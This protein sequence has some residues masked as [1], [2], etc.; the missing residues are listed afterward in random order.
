MLLQSYIQNCQRSLISSLAVAIDVLPPPP[1]MTV[2][3]WADNYRRLSSETSAEPGRWET[4]RAEYQREIMNAITDPSVETVVFMSSAQVGKTEI[5]NNVVGYHIDQDPCPIF[6][7]QP[8]LK[9]AETWSKKRFTPMVKESPTLTRKVKNSRGRDSDNTLLEKGF[10]GGYVVMSG[11][12][13]PASLA[14]RPIRILLCDEVDRYPVSA[15]TEGDPVNLAIKRT[16]TFWNKKIVL[17]STPTVKGAS[18]IE[19]AYEATDKR[20]FFVPCPHC[21]E[22]QY[23]KWANIQWEDG[24]VFYV[25]EFCGST[26]EEKHKL[27]MV[28]GGEWIATSEATAA[29]T[30]GFHL[31]ELYSPWVTWAE[32][33]GNFLEAKKFPE[34]LKTWV[35]TALGETWEEE[36]DGVSEDALQSRERSNGV[37]DAVVYITAGVDVQKDRVE[38]SVI[39]WGVGEEAWVIDHVVLIGD[40]QRQD[41]WN[42]LAEQLDREFQGLETMKISRMFID[43]GHQTQEVY[44]F[45]LEYSNRGVF[46]VKGQSQDG[47]PV[48]ARPA[49]RKRGEAKPVPIGTIAAKDVVFGRLKIEDPGPGYIHFADHLE[50]EYFKQLTAEQVFIKYVQGTPRR[51]YK[52]VRDR[53]EALDCFVYGYA[54]MVFMNSVRLDVKTR[55]RAKRLER[56]KNKQKTEKPQPVRRALQPLKPVRKGFTYGWK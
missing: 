2:S 51:Y 18:R 30:V 34:T 27:S 6:V 43:S 19:A 14:S 35:N 13:S 16:T 22:K 39:G 20:R 21:K 32:M 25:C 4:S 50:D 47:K 42:Q 3:E 17:I 26:I 31:S 10:H 40:T 5:V 7:L 1:E 45:A 9:L 37:H 28:A 38:C 46:A 23:L 55:K 48:T 33:V 41:V 49:K 24:L 54:A 12:N 53:N 8:T 29:K 56:I 36:G 15:G 52:Q 44:R 11:A